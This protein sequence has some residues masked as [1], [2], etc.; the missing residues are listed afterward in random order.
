M[1]KPQQVSTQVHM[2]TS[3]DDR[4]GSS[5]LLGKAVHRLTTIKSCVYKHVEKRSGPASR[6]RRR[7]SES[8]ST[9]VPARHRRAT[10]RALG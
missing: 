5:D 10:F 4:A 7:E 8:W 6:S 3:R 1:K 9:A 2:N